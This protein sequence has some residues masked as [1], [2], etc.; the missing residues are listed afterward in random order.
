MFNGTFNL[1]SF[2][3]LYF[4]FLHRDSRAV[5][6]AQAMICNNPRNLCHEAMIKLKKK[7]NKRES[8]RTFF[9][10]NFFIFSFIANSLTVELD[11][12]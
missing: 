12:N 8:W 9:F 10:L 11:S 6:V 2:S 3:L 5:N 4:F 1:Y 7:A